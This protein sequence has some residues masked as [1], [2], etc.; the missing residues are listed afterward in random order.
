MLMMDMSDQPSGWSPPVVATSALKEQGTVE[1]LGHIDNHLA[2]LKSSGEITA[3]RR[4]IAEWRLLHS[5]EGLLQGEFAKHRGGR[6]STFTQQLMSRDLSPRMA[7]KQLI[8][9]VFRENRS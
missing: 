7:A 9:N 6:L 5:A 3:R 4:R 2:Y 8:D 1:L